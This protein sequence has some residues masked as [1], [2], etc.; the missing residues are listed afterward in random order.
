MV[1]TDHEPLK[2]LYSQPN[3][4][5]RQA[6]WLEKLSELQLEVVYLPGRDNIVADV[7]SRYG[8]ERGSS[9]A[10]PVAHYDLA[11]VSLHPRLCEWLRVVAPGV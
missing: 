8:H 10:I 1:Y 11:D 7:L 9:S 3:I 2:Y 5:S 6:R 4:S